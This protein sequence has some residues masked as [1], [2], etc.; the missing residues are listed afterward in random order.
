[1]KKFAKI[2]LC[3]LLTCSFAF[4]GCSLVQKNTARYLNKT[5]A[6]AG[7]NIT[8][9]MQDLLTS[10]NSYGYQYVNMYGYTTEKAIKL[11]LD[12][13]IDKKLVL[14][15]AKK[16]ILV[17]QV[18]NK[19]YFLTFDE[20]GNEVERRLIFNKN[21]WQND[22]LQETYDAINSQ[23][24]EKEKTVRKELGLEEETE[25]EEKE[26]APFDAYKPYEKTVKYEDGVWSIIYDELEPEEEPIGD[27]VQAETGNKE[28]SEIAFKRYI[29]SLISYEKS[30]GNNVTEEKALQNEIE[31]IYKSVE[32]NKYIS[33]FEEQFEKT[34]TLSTEFNKRVV[35]YYKNLVLSSAE[36]Y[37]MLGDDGYD[38]YVEDMQSD[39]DAVYYHPYG[40]KFV[41][42]SHVLI[43]LTDDQLAEIKDLDNKLSTGVI[44][45]QER[46]VEYQKI[47]D[48][49]VVHAR[50]ENGFE[51]EVTKTVSEVYDEINAELSKYNTVEEKAIA[52]N[53]F[54]YKYGQDEGVINAESYYVV[55][56]DTEV[57]DKMV[58]NFADKSRE[59]YAES[60]KGGNLSEPV[61]VA[62]SNYSGYHIIF[63]AGGVSS[64]LSI[65]QVNSLTSDYAVNLY[66][67]KVMLGT[68]KTYYDMIFDK[69]TRSDY[70]KYEKSITDTAKHNI[71]VVIYD[72]RLEELY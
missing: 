13:I 31:R 54:I 28:V 66:N 55:N 1:M 19:V 35:D 58:K 36:K 29:K 41:E 33:V 27:F 14:E 11:V 2:L 72:S 44:G 12:E 5:V 63:N 71:Q 60:N 70:K 43:K 23:I 17:D 21:V 62:S 45:Q 30:I 42:V 59:L 48:K 61:F 25:S 64:N 18:E 22:I 51:I 15:E 69:L 46:D 47:L 6:T 24:A 53:K 16:H 52:F 39:A 50:D 57:E 49:T 38:Q 65:E 26:E 40:E 8:I 68:E 37:A 67:K 56:L 4:T 3:L 10:Y 32:E 34:Q 9:T 20:E 7:D